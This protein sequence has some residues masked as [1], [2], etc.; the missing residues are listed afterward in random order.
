MFDGG[1]P[2][3]PGGVGGTGGITGAGGTCTI[4][5]FGG[6]VIHLVFATAWPSFGGA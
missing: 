3:I 4:G 5:P 6:G 1:G 2:S